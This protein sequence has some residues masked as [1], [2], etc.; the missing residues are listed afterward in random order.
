MVKG[1]ENIPVPHSTGF[2]YL[3]AQLLSH[4]LFR[5][6]CNMKTFPFSFWNG[7]KG[8]QWHFFSVI[9]LLAHSVPSHDKLP[10]ST[11]QGSVILFGRAITRHFPACWLPAVGKFIS[12][13]MRMSI[14]CK[15]VLQCTKTAACSPWFWAPE[16]QIH[17]F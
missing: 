11:E 1:R 16:V 7:A 10:S 9:L 3:L 13:R 6:L 17:G 2:M 15:P 12:S 8:H 4:A 5:Q 14:V